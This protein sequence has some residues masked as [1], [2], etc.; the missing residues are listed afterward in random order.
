MR[1]EQSLASALS[2]IAG[3]TVDL[4]NLADAPLDL[5]GRVLEEGIRICSGD[6]V[7]RVGLERDL[8]GRHHDYKE[9]L[10]AMRETRLE[11]LAQPGLPGMV[12]KPKLDQALESVRRT[13][14]EPCRDPLR[15]RARGTCPADRGRRRRPE[16]ARL[17]DGP[18]ASGR[19][20]T[21]WR[22]PGRGA[23]TWFV[24]FEAGDRTFVERV[25][26]LR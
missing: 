3:V 16:I 20:R 24:R 6:D 9:E 12:D 13:Q 26:T 22:A 25:T 17:A 5:R 15:R 4:R 21:T 1:D 10:R 2:D 23:G 7:T 19:Y 18:L 11:R 14:G 8:L